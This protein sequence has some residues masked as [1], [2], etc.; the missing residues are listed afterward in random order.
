MLE[1]RADRHDLFR[2][3]EAWLVYAAIHQRMHHGRGA[4]VVRRKVGRD[5]SAN[6]SIAPNNQNASAR[7]ASSE[8]CSGRWPGCIQVRPRSLQGIAGV[9][10]IDNAP[11]VVPDIA[12]AVLLQ[13]RS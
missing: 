4:G 10:P 12:V 6:N 11:P 5:A 8:T 1:E 3:P 13:Q 7:H 9:L 2:T